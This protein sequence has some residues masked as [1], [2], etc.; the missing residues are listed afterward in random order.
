MGVAPEAGNA[1]LC[2]ANVANLVRGEVVAAVVGSRHGH[3]SVE[4]EVGGAWGARTQRS[5]SGFT[6]VTIDELRARIT[7]G[8]L[9]IVKVGIEGFESDLFATATEWIARTVRLSWN[10]TIGCRPVRE[11]SEPCRAAMLHENRELLISGD[12]LIWIRS[13]PN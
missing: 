4:R 10:R 9:L 11:A 5:E 3:V 8:E 7:D 12:N 6:V 1:A 2:R 13:V